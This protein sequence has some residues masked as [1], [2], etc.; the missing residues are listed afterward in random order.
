MPITPGGS[1]TFSSS[2]DL[3]REPLAGR[4]RTTA[5][6]WLARSRI[7]LGALV[8]RA[9]RRPY[10]SAA[11]MSALVAEREAAAAALAE[12][13]CRYR[14][15]IDTMG[16][17]VYTTDTQG[18]LTLYNEAAVRLWGCRPALGDARFCG[19]WKL[20]TPDGEPLPHDEC[21]MAV[22]LR[23]NRVVTGGEAVAERPDGTRVPF[24]AYP[25]PLRDADGTL[26]GAVNVLMDITE[27]KSLE[28]QLTTAN[29][30]LAILSTIDC[31]TGLANR[32][33]FDRVLSNEW[34]R[35][36]R[37]QCPLSLLLIDADCFKAY[38]D[39]H[40][41]PAGDAVLKAV[42]ACLRDNLRRSTDLAARYG[43]EE[44]AVVLPNTGLQGAADVAEEIRRSVLALGL[45]HGASA[46]GIVSVSIG[47]A[48][49]V[50]HDGD[51]AT[52]L[53]E[54]ADA[55]LYEAK[56]R[57]RNRTEVKPVLLA[58]SEAMTA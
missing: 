54:R 19:A 10:A 55:A 37:E 33:Q 11:K 4:V 39:A 41:H 32:R 17:A 24:A 49:V 14:G 38:N 9:S 26:V 47:V 13:E 29:A 53:L 27:R 30:E 12:A 34:G 23:E 16:V 46:L 15:L 2:F 28:N 6:A 45:P 43:G 40:G 42:A 48:A 58:A 35:A 51:S 18:R 22:A 44:F 20:Y 1:E 31:L 52:S 50:P 7:G 25:A 3:D 21:P 5:G 36:E 57:G 56:R 8:R